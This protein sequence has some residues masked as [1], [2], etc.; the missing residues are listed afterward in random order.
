[1]AASNSVRRSQS[2]KQCEVCESNSKIKVKC[3][4]CDRLMCETCKR[5]HSKYKD[6]E[7][8]K[9]VDIKDINADDEDKNERGKFK[10]VRCSNHIDQICCMYCSSCNK[11]VC[12]T[13]IEDNHQN[14]DLK[15]IDSGCKDRLNKIL[16][17]HDEVST[18]TILYL[19]KLDILEKVDHFQYEEILRQIELDKK[20]AMEKVEQKYNDEKKKLGGQRNLISSLLTSRKDKIYKLQGKIDQEKKHLNNIAVSKDTTK[21]VE[22]AEEFENKHLKEV[23]DTIHSNRYN[24]KTLR[25]TPGIVFG[26]EPNTTTNEIDVTFQQAFKTDFSIKDLKIDKSKTI[27]TSSIDSINQVEAKK[28]VEN[29]NITKRTPI[30]ADKGEI[31]QIEVMDIDDLVFIT[32]T[33]IYRCNKRD[34]TIKKIV[35]LTENKPRSIHI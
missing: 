17:V 32:S 27:W 2:I 5:N 31:R 8:H 18:E 6:A 9:L 28:G 24:L 7:I 23:T 33:G 10:A 26:M 16:K 11:L 35:G 25:Y 20:E 30:L 13:C 29:L 21:F 34:E 22:K 4:D 19:Q 1:M 12:P 3:I 14:H 15:T